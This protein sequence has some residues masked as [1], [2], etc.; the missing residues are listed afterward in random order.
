MKKILV[1]IILIVLVGVAGFLYRNRVERPL[2]SSG[3]CTTE[4][5]LCPDGSSV[6]RT[7]PSCTFAKCA[8]P[9]VELSDIGISFASPEGFKE[10]I[11]N[12]IEAS[13]AAYERID[14]IAPPDTVTLR[15]YEIPTDRTAN[16]VMMEK[17]IFS[18]K[19]E[20][21]QSMDDFAKVEIGG[22]AFYRALVERFEGQV[23]IAYY[24]PR[25]HDVLAFEAID[26]NVENWMD[27]DLAIDTLPTQ[28]ALLSLL[29]TLKIEP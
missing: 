17:T 12:P 19:G 18:P 9:N 21:A 23:H 3:M 15:R 1:C 2:S 14:E 29:E 10:G 26:R 27:A 6:G 5:K 11:A 25:T 28:A 24:L 4:A 20:A 13:V 22:R 8:P 7:G 16:A